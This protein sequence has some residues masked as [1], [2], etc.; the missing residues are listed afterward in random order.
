MQIPQ[1]A[2]DLVAAESLLTDDPLADYWTNEAGSWGG[3]T[4]QGAI[5]L[6]KIE[7]G[8]HIVASIQRVI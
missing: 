3:T 2:Q 5:V 6:G 4:N 7:E 1:E 8:S